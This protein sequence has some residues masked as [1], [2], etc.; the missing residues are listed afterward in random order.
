MSVEIRVRPRARSDLEEATQ[1]YE[2]QRTGLGSDF[3]DEVERAFGKIAENPFV[4]P[5]VHRETRR[6]LLQRFPFGVF[7]RVTKQAVTVIS[8]MHSSRD[9]RRWMTRT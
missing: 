7:Y 2:S 4:Y 9:P 8:V 3:L 1:W 6:A 5:E